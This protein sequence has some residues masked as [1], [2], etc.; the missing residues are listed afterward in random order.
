MNTEKVTKTIKNTHQGD[1]VD[2]V[3]RR[4]GMSILELARRAGVSDTTMRKYL[5]S[6]AFCHKM[7]YRLGQILKE[8]FVTEFPELLSVKQELGVG[9]SESDKKLLLLHQENKILAKRNIQ[10]TRL[11]AKIAANC[12]VG[13]YSAEISNACMSDA[14]F[15]MM[16]PNNPI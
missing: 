8:D 5:K 9:F 11:L 2:N 1:Y 10:L 15:L 4:Y 13:V 16:Q 12:E 3:R 6:E 7:F 14:E